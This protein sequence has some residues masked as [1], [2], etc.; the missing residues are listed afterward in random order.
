MERGILTIHRRRATKQGVKGPSTSGEGV[1]W[2]RQ[3]R[4]GHGRLSLVLLRFE[5][6]C[7]LDTLSGLPLPSSCPSS[8]QCPWPCNKRI[9]SP[10]SSWAQL[11]ERWLCCFLWPVE[12][13]AARLMA[14][15]I[16]AE[17]LKC[18]LKP[19]TRPAPPPARPGVPGSQK[20]FLNDLRFTTGHNSLEPNVILRICWVYGRGEREFG[21]CFCLHF[22]SLFLGWL[23][24]VYLSVNFLINLF[25]S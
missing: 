8:L 23:L 24:R 20:H 15:F 17:Q 4:L 9:L 19:S 22:L 12:P 25:L 18:R 11:Q 2:T 21:V 14:G 16:P 1:P 10:G 3:T 7:F 6:P 5:G 13:E